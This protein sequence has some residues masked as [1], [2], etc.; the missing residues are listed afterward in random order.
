M[1]GPALVT[2]HETAEDGDAG[3]NDGEGGLD[4]SPDPEVNRVDCT[5]LAGVSGSGQD[6]SSL[7]TRRGLPHQSQ[8]KAW[9]GTWQF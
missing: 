6:A 9:P 2:I 5:S 3:G 4:V 7:W 1:V 8:E